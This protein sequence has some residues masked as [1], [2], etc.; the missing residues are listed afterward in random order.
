MFVEL[1]IQHAKRMNRI[2]LSCLWPVRLYQMF[3]HYLKTARFSGKSYRIQ[4]MCFDFLYKFCL[5]FYFLF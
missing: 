5:I 1:G 3:K 4:N 2:T